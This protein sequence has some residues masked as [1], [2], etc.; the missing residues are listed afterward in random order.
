[1]NLTEYISASNAGNMDFEALSEDF[2]FV[3]NEV[4]GDTELKELVPTAQKAVEAFKK[5][6]NNRN[7][8]SEVASLESLKKKDKITDAYKAAVEKVAKFKDLTVRL[9]AVKDSDTAG[10]KALKAELKTVI[11]EIPKTTSFLTK[12]FPAIEAAKS[13]KDVSGAQKKAADTQ[14]KDDN[15][16]SVQKDRDQISKIDTAKAKAQEV[17][18]ATTRKRQ[19][20]VQASVDRKAARP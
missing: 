20:K 12:S 5:A 16:A 6:M 10:R 19:A 11:K 4:I 8:A 9:N 15:T 14:A 18:A 17:G 7:L 1:M 2:D 3:L 13:A